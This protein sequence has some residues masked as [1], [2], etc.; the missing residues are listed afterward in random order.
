MALSNFG[1]L[2]T[3]VASWLNRTDLASVI[4]DFVRLAESEI[5]RDLRIRAM[6]ETATGSMSSGAITL[7][8]DFLE[9][10]RLVVDDREMSYITP[11]EY[12]RLVR[13]GYSD[14][15]Y[16]THIGQSIF[17]L[18]GEA[19]SYSLLYWAKFDAL[20]ADADTNWLLTNHPDLY[21]FKACE[22]GAVFLRDAEGATGYRS[23]YDDAK[24]KLETADRM[25]EFSGSVLEIRPN[26]VAA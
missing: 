2:K 20:S 11:E 10:R 16:F 21:L 17:V 3:S 9:A 4:P 14:V 6:Q 12:Q 5:A 23:L 25:A 22:K 15:R 19:D 18:N 24:A 26:N 7:P 8:S 1:D 13:D